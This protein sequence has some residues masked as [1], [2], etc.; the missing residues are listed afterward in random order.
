MREIKFRGKR[1]GNGEWVY[2]FY[3]RIDND[4]G[5]IK[6]LSETKHFI[7][8]LNTAMYEVIS[9]TVGQ[10][11]GLKDKNDKEIFE[12]DIIKDEYGNYLIVKWNEIFGCWEFSGV[13]LSDYGNPD[14]W[15]KKIKVIGNIHDNSELLK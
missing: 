11:T 15:L 12:D 13:K 10:Y 14:F 3:I 9:E 7:K 1:K 5:V 8:Q 2:G 4:N 6:N